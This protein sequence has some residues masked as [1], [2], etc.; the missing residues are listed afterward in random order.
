MHAGTKIIQFYAQTVIAVAW[1]KWFLSARCTSPLPHRWLHLNSTL[2]C[3]YFVFH[4]LDFPHYDFL[5]VL[6]ESVAT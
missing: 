5:V 6:A 3:T 1:K 2:N 4:S